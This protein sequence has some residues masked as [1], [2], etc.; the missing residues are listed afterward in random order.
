MA[1]SV[2]PTQSNTLTAV[3]SFL[4]AVLPD[5]TDVVQGQQNRV[6]E[7]A[8]GTSNYVIMTPLRAPR[9]STNVDA[10]DD[11]SFTGS[12]SGAVLTVTDMEF[13]AIRIG[14]PLFGVGVADPTEITGQ[15]FGDPGGVGSYTIKPAQDVSAEPM[16]AGVKTMTQATDFTVQLDFHGPAAT[17]MAQVVSTTMRDEYAVGLFAAQ[18]PNYGVS[19]LLADDPRQM[20]FINDQKQYENRW[21]VEARFQVNPVVVVPQQFAD[22]LSIEVISVDERFPPAAP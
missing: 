11:V 17:D 12:A 10:E 2:S 1:L 20:P 3:R 21:I 22:A 4:L 13:G 14:A 19:P 8:P 5:G 7:P 18:N 6:P 16:S 15:T 9:L